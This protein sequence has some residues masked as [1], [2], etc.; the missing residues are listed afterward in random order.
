MVQ[1]G[2]WVR[3]KTLPPW[4]DLLPQES[5]EVFRFC[6]GR[7]YRVDEINEHGLIV[8][9]VS[10]DIDKKFGGYRNDIRVEETYID[11]VEGP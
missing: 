10:S 2:D 3:L 5:Q 6:V 7:I 9:D 4:V 1:P 8:L 11:V